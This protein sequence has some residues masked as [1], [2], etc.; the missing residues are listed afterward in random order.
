[1]L[2]KSKYNSKAPN[3]AALSWSSIIIEYLFIF[4]TSYATN[5]INK[6]TPIQ[7]KIISNIALFRN[8][9]ITVAI[10]IPINPIINIVEYLDKSIFVKYPNKA[11]IKTLPYPGFPTDM[12]SQFMALLTT[13][14][15]KST[16]IETV[17]E[18]R[19]LHVCELQ[20][21]GANLRIDGRQVSIHGVKELSGAPVMVS[22]LRA[23][24]ALVLAG[25]C[26]KGKTEISRI[27]HLDR[28]Y[29]TLEEKFKAVGANIERIK[30]DI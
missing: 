20:R 29:E 13:V 14:E 26:A 6:I 4:W 12:Q 17:F 15:G 24:A 3:I 28:G 19:F 25:L 11:N 23:G 7:L 1:M 9:L 27:Y 10:S 21:L 8:M 22:D 16:V 18:N 30:G 2:I 5:P